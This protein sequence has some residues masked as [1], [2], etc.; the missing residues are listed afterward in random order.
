MGPE[1]TNA[2]H[3]D[4]ICAGLKAGVDGDVHK[5]QAIWDANLSVKNWGFLLVYTENASNYINCIGILWTVCHLWPSRDSFV[6]NCYCNWS[7]L[8]L[9]NGNGT[10]SF[11]QSREGVTQGD[12][13]AMAAY[14]IGILLLIK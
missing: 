12:P 1:A 14:V 11:L 6:Y 7:Y 8:V 4:Q 3:Y 10:A 5:V 2:C 9:Q 13:L